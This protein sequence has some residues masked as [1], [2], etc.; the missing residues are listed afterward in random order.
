MPVI[1]VLLL[2]PPHV[3][4]DLFSVSIECKYYHLEYSYGDVDCQKLIILELGEREYGLLVV[5]V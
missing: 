2:Q 3:V 1:L 5:V 4:E